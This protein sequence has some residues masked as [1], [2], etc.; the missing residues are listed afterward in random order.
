MNVFVKNLERELHTRKVYQG[1]VWSN[2][3]TS[4]VKNA[5]SQ[6]KQVLRL[7]SIAGHGKGDIDHVGSVAKIATKHAIWN[8][9]FFENSSD[10]VQY[11]SEKFSNN[12]LYPFQE[13]DVKAL[14][15]ERTEDSLKVFDTVDDSS[16][17]QVAVFTPNSETFKAAC[18]LCLCDSCLSKHGSCEMF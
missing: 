9:F 10:M 5:N 2:P 11:L 15:E 16:V 14:E 3:K 7:W 8:D 13:I 6:Q 1:F 17:F 18:H 12:L 4:N